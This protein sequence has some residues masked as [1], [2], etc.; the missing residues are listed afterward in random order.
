M[1]QRMA[2]QWLQKALILGSVAA[3][4]MSLAEASTHHVVEAGE[5]LSGIAAQYNLSTTM[6]IDANG[7]QASHIRPG[8]VLN[9]PRPDAQHNIYRV[10][11]GDSLTGLAKQHGL[12]VDALARANHMS[13]QSGLMIGST[14]VIPVTKAKDKASAEVTEPSSATTKAVS[15]A[16]T[17]ETTAK[18]SAPKPKASAQPPAATPKQTHRIEYGET[19]LSIA[20]KYHINVMQL[21]AANDMSINDTLYFGRIL[22]IPSDSTVPAAPNAPISTPQPQVQTYT[23]K[24]GDTL[25]GIANRYQVSFLDIAA[26]SNISPYDALAIGQVLSLP[27]GARHVASS[28]P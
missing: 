11:A 10:V 28:T 22:N 15:N 19:L 6:L 2:R 14:L 9:I 12:T 25:M 26:K 23:V 16:K 17:V 4:S 7:L 21:A 5:T 24:R 13:P 27:S 20:N 3:L 1:R 8:K 18:K